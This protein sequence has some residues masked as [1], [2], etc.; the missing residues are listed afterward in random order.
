MLEK[1]FG[2]I[3]ID[4]RQKQLEI[5]ANITVIFCRIMLPPKSIRYFICPFGYLILPYFL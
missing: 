3:P 1:R 4:Y 2:Q 5:S